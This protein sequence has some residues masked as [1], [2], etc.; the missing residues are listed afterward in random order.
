MF[1]CL[2]D[3]ARGGLWS[4]DEAEYFLPPSARDSSDASS[5][6]LAFQRL[7]GKQSAD[8]DRF[9]PVLVLPALS[10]RHGAKCTGWVFNG[11]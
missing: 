10:V 4:T 7:I 2:I 5:C 6:S 8:L 11:A 3:S 9:D 1:L